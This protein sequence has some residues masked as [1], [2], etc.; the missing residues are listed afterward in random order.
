MALND[1]RFSV[2]IVEQS[3]YVFCYNWEGVSFTI[4]RY[5]LGGY[6]RCVGVTTKWSRANSKPELHKCPHCREP[7]LK[8]DWRSRA[9][10]TVVDLHVTAYYESVDRSADDCAIDTSLIGPRAFDAA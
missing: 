8:N 10:R 4:L 1:G 7:V 9:V 2:K 5:R 3:A 6:P